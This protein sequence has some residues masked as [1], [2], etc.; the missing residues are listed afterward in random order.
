MK[1]KQA[2]KKFWHL[3]WKDDSLKGWIISLIVI[4]VFVKFIFFPT[5]NLVTGTKLP[6]MVVESCSMYHQRDLFTN[7]DNWWKL[8]GEQYST[9]IIDKSDFQKFSLKNG[10]NKGDIMFAV[11]VKPG[12]LKIGDIIIFNA[13]QYHPIIHRI[14]EIK[15][16]NNGYV[17]STK[18][19]NNNGQLSVEKN[20]Q[21]DQIISKAVLKIPYLGWTKLIFFDWKNSADQRGFCK[22]N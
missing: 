21:S 4:F 11:G 17:F 3:V 9:Y 7:F 15:K 19:D 8:K 13:D 14:I 20:I 10:F 18:G 22:Q 1:I 6:L 2:L 16:D 12:N 5:L